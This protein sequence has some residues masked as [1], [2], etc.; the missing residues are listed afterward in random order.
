MTGANMET[1]YAS[2]NLYKDYLEKDEN[3]AQTAHELFETQKMLEYFK[4]EEKRLK[5]ELKSQSGDT[6]CH[7]G[8]YY[9]RCDVRKGNVDYGRIPA[10]ESMSDEELDSY[11]KKDSHTWKLSKK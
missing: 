1:T 8:D 11:R 10:I 4:N 6:N 2:I 9:F 5:E 3:W 7:G